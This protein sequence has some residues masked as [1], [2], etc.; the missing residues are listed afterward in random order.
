[1]ALGKWGKITRNS[2]NSWRR[3]LSLSKINYR[4]YIR[5]L[6]RNVLPTVS[7]RKFKHLSKAA[8]HILKQQNNYYTEALKALVAE[9]AESMDQLIARLD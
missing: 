2:K 6:S 1:M 7:E 4:N 5:D 8:L 9:D 3:K